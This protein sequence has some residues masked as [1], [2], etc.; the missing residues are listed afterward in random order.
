[1]DEAI[2]KIMRYPDCGYAPLLICGAPNGNSEKLPKILEVSLV[3]NSTYQI[4]KE[5]IV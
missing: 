4:T 2:L 3:P 1:M 5:D